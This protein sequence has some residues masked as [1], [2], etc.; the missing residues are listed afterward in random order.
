MAE[1]IGILASAAALIQLV[2][3]GKKSA[4]A[5]HRFSHRAGFSKPDVE[6]C[7]NHLRT[8]SL[9]VSLAVE[10]LDEYDADTNTSPVFDFMK[11]EQVIRVISIDSDSLGMRL[12][13]VVK[14]FRSLSRGSRTP[15]AFVKW[16]LHKDD[17]ITLFPEMERIKTNLTLIIAAIQLKLVYTKIKMQSS[18]SLAIRKLKKKKYRLESSIR[19][20]LDMLAK[21]EDQ[22]EC[23]HQRISSIGQGP[24]IAASNSAYEALFDWGKALRRLETYQTRHLRRLGPL[25]P[26]TSSKVLQLARSCMSMRKTYLKLSLVI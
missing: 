6:R 20:H 1:V 5:L 12:N 4:R 26:R 9:A 10:T 18:D 24:S 22:I 23:A 17:V 2:S 14:R 21:L 3:Y 8:F 13:L 7:A 16:W 19:T 25:F 11:S 15:V